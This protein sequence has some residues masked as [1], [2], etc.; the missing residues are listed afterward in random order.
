MEIVITV[1][2]AL[3]TFDWVGQPTRS[4]SSMNSAVCFLI[5]EIKS[6]SVLGMNWQGRQESNPRPSDLES[7]ALPT[8]LLP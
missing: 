5:K 6:G 8:E 2:E 1:H 3:I 4:S 7:E